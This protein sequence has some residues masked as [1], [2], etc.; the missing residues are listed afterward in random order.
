[1][2]MR[3]GSLFSA[4]CGSDLA[5]RA[6]PRYM[7]LARKL[8]TV[9]SLTVWASFS[10]NLARPVVLVSLV[11]RWVRAAC[12]VRFRRRGAARKIVNISEMVSSEA[13][14]LLSFSKQLTTSQHYFCSRRYQT[15][16]LNSNI[17]FVISLKYRCVLQ[18]QHWLYEWWIVGMPKNS[19][20]STSNFWGWFLQ[21]DERR[22]IVP[23]IANPMD[24]CSTRES[25]QLS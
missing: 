25:I 10:Q 13:A 2:R 4:Y 14:C 24:K 19:I 12:L 3:R 16:F 21:N 18:A 17:Y 1:M 22:T 7:G 6:P 8:F 23:A 5:L 11:P 9:A 15:L 20:C